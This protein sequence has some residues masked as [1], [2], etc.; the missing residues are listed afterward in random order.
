MKIHRVVQM[1]GLTQESGRLASD[2]YDLNNKIYRSKSTNEEIPIS[3]MDFQHAIRTL[4]KFCEQEEVDILDVIKA[5]D[6]I[7]N[8]LR[9]QVETLKSMIEVETNFSKE[10]DAIIDKLSKE[11]QRWRKAYANDCYTQGWRYVFSEIPNDTDGQEFVDTMKKYLNKESYKMR[12][13]G[14]HLK[15]ELYG[16]NRAYHGANL[17]DSTHMRVYIDVKKGDE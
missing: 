1:L 11:E 4:V 6:S 15:K 8:G 17:G 13:K 3:H 10:K 9:S 2:M 16:Q 5:K 14:Q 12:V 7:I